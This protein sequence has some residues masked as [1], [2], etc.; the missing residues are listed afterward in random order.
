MDC[1]SLTAGA[2]FCGAMVRFFKFIHARFTAAGTVII[3]AGTAV[4]AQSPIEILMAATHSAPIVMPFKISAQSPRKNAPFLPPQKLTHIN[5]G[6][7]RARTYINSL[8]GCICTASS[9]AAHRLPKVIPHTK[10]QKSKQY[11]PRV[12]STKIP[13]PISLCKGRD[14]NCT[15]SVLS[16]NCRLF[17]TSVHGLDKSGSEAVL[18]QAVYRFD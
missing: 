14:F 18:F 9:P 4:F 3:S 6:K 7:F 13:S 17:G 12:F 16:Q 5:R 2:F 10:K 15:C 11:S 1:K 8:R